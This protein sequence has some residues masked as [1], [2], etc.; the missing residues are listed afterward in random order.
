MVIVFSF[1]GLEMVRI[2]AGGEH[3]LG[4]DA[5]NWQCK[6]CSAV[7]ESS[8]ALSSAAAVGGRL[9]RTV[10]PEGQKGAPSLEDVRGP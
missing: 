6:I 4:D 2:G 3:A 8:N 10:R 1:V 9:R 5:G 7:F